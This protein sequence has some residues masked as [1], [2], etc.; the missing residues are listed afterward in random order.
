MRYKD[1]I[2]GHTIKRLRWAMKRLQQ[3]NEEIAVKTM[4]ILNWGNKEIQLWK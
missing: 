4:K 1:I 2:L 3:G